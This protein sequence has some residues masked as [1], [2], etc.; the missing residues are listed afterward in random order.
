MAEEPKRKQSFLGVEVANLIQNISRL[1]DKGEY[2][3]SPND[4]IEARR[5]LNNVLPKAV[6]VWVASERREAFELGTHLNVADAD[7]NEFIQS[8]LNNK[9]PPFS[10]G[11]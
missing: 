7:L 5:L 4:F 8:R 6:D 3:Q 1:I 11:A 10:A 2:E 9:K